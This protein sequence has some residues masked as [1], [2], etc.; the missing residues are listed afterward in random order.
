MW[1]KKH[2]VQTYGARGGIK[3]VYTQGVDD[4]LWTIGEP[5]IGSKHT[6]QRNT[7][8]PRVVWHK[9]VAEEKRHV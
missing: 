9:G 6:R 7:D 5:R 8:R 2:G 3:A 1:G 4:K